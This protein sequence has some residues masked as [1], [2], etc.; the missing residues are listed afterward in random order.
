MKMFYELPMGNISN[1]EMMDKLRIKELIEF[2]RYC[3]DNSHFEQ[4]KTCWW[5]DG[6]VF[7]TWF[8]GSI[9]EFLKNSGARNK[10][11]SKHKI[12]SIVV[13]LKD[14]RAIAECIC[15]IT[16]RTKL[17]HEQID[18]H[19]WCRLHFRVEKRD[20]RWG[21]VYFEG[22]YEKDRIDP[23]FSDSKW[24]VPREELTKFRPINWNMCFRL[25]NYSADSFGGGLQFSEYWAGADKPETVQK[26]YEDS[27]RWLGL[28]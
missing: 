10:T 14:N 15:T 24:Y 26:L 20:E 11:P 3:R 13:W 7:A 12:N 25:T 28:E 21:I 18:L 9:D 23:V 8:K 17:G 22:I 16:Y 1:E 4:E 5:E 6:Q 2:E 19:S 27:S